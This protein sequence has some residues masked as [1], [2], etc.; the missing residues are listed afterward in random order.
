MTGTLVGMVRNN[1]LYA[2][3]I[4]HLGRPEMVTNPTKAVVWRA[5]NCAFHRYVARD[6]IGW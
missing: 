3:H 1:V 4:D 6:K 2:I 5:N